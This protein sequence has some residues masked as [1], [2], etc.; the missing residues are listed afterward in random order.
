MIGC[1]VIEPE[2]HQDNP[3]DGRQALM[4]AWKDSLGEASWPATSALLWHE[5]SR[6]YQVDLA[7]QNIFAT[8]CA[9]CH[10]AEGGATTD[11]G[12]QI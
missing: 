12:H 6:K 2:K 5:E 8:N 7:G 4:P 3:G 9:S 10:G 1:T 11:H